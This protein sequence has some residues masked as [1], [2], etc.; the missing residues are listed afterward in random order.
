MIYAM[1]KGE[2][3]IAFVGSAA[4]IV[5][6]LVGA[7]FALYPVVLPASSDPLRNLTIY[8]TAAGHHGLTVG[9]TW[10]TLGMVLLLATSPCCSACSKGKCGRRAKGTESPQGL[11]PGVF[12]AIFGHACRRSRFWGVKSR[13]PG[14][15]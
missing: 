15:K 3:K 8:N 6:M 7:A 9:L 14:R 10:W 1:R 12:S 4:Y 5:S 2:D 11:K 13:P